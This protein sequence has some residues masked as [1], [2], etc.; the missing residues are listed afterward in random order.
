MGFWERES[1]RNPDAYIQGLRAAA[2]GGELPYGI[3]REEAVCKFGKVHSQHAWPLVEFLDL[4]GQPQEVV[5]LYPHK[6]VV[7]DGNDNEVICSRVQLPVLPSYALT[8]HKVGG[9]V[10]FAEGLFAAELVPPHP[11]CVMC[12]C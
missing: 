5:K 11:L 3:G 1:L 7:V 6:H 4:E 2:D 12:G 9:M 10:A 8:I